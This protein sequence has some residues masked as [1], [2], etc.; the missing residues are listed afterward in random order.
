MISSQQE[1]QSSNLKVED[2]SLSNTSQNSSVVT[3]ISKESTARQIGDYFEYKYGVR[4]DTGTRYVR[5]PEEAGIIVLR[6]YGCQLDVTGAGFAEPTS[7]D[8]KPSRIHLVNDGTH[9]QS[10]CAEILQ[11]VLATYIPNNIEEVYSQATDIDALTQWRDYQ[12]QHDFEPTILFENR[13]I[14]ITASGV[15]DAEMVAVELNFKPED[16]ANP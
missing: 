8:Q 11:E 3:S 1:I 5:S 2:S 12:S 4:R 14:K 7:L 9:F 10:F 13:N 15:T 6:D 16:S